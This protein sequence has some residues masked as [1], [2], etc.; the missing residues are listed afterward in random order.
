MNEDQAIGREPCRLHKAQG[1]E[2][3]CSR[4]KCIYW[5]LIESQ[6]LDMSN[7]QGCGLQFYQMLDTLSPEMAEWLLKMKNRLENTTP[8]AGKSRITFKRREQE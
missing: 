2:A 7:E 4:D 3:W 5:R 8:E 6:D 1:L